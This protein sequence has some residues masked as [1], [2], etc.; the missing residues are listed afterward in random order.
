MSWNDLPSSRRELAQGILTP[1][2]LRIVQYRLDDVP[3]RQ[4]AITLGKHE[5]TIRYHHA[6]A[7]DLLRDARKDAA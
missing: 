1:L 2:Q 6:R 3:W 4:I 5:S 7:I